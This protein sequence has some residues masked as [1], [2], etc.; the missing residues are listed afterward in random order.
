M[1][2]QKEAAAALAN[3]L[4]KV[5]RY[6]VILGIGGSAVQASLYTGMCTMLLGSQ[7]QPAAP[8]A[9]AGNRWRASQ[10][11]ARQLG[12]RRLVPW[13][14]PAGLTA[15]RPPP[16]ACRLPLCSLQWMAASVR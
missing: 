3:L 15:S 4:S 6:S 10:G 2:A 12:S 14:P 7:P 5:A 13:A 8:A 9:R 11:D 16:P 1:A